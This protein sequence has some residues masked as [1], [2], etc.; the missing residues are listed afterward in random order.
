[1]TERTTLPKKKTARENV[2][3]AR[4]G[5]ESAR[6]SYDSRKELRQKG[7]VSEYELRTAAAAFIFVPYSAFWAVP[8]FPKIQ[9]NLN[10]KPGN[11]RLVQQVRVSVAYEVQDGPH[12]PGPYH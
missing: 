9:R 10:P 12:S 1:M 2:E 5:A 3:V 8:G 6:L 7:I 4:A 11:S